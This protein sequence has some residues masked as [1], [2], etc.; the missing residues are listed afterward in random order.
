MSLRLLLLSCC[1]L[2]P[3]AC[4]GEAETQAPALPPTPQVATDSVAQERIAEDVR[5]L[6]DDAMQGRMAGTPGHERAAEHVAARMQAAGL[7]PAGDDGGWFQTVPLLRST[8]LREGA[9]LQV[10]H[11]DRDVDLRFEDQF[12][13]QPDFNVGEARIEA[14]AVFVRQAVHAPALGIDDFAGLDVQGKVAVL[15]NGAP[16]SLPA[17]PRAHHAAM[18]SKLQTLAA[19]GALAAVLVNSA[20]DEAGVPWAVTAGNWQRPGLRL[21]DAHGAAI[22][23]VPQLRVVTRVSASAADLLFDGSGRTASQVH[24]AM[25]AGEPGFALPV[26]LALASASRIEPLQSR[27]VLGRLPGNDT[28]LAG[29]AIAWTAHLDHLGEGLAIDGDG[30]HNGALDNALGVAI[31]LESARMLADAPRPPRR[32][33]LFAALTAEEHGLLGA[34]WLVRQ[35]PAGLGFVAN[36]NID[37]P[38]LLAPSKDV[39]AIGSEHSSLGDAVAAVAADL[40]VDLSPDPFPEEA[41][42]VRSDQYAF[43][44]A[45]VPALYLD[46]GVVSADGKRHPEL[47]QRNFMREH[48]HRPSDDLSLPVYWPDAER[49]ARLAAE[50]GSVISEAD[51]PPQW[52]AGDFFQTLARD[53]A[54]ARP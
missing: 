23:G 39:I 37:M 10:R 51:A 48:Y 47:A 11:R 9:Q 4:K 31:M 35:P 46:A 8:R 38:L 17:N 49:L 36:L 50:L 29:E 7:K 52:N 13:P 5:T 53:I 54:P 42:F 28:V 43:A 44:R 16:P 24:A 19:R 1:L 40:G 26:R 6:A 32:T 20:A 22:D 2:L 41:A 3:T 21:R 12:L 18:E 15:F 30:I 27:N 25:L 14:E 33:L 34:R 45:G